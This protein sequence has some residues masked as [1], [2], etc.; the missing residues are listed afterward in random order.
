MSEVL[1]ELLLF[2]Y[3]DLLIIQ[4]QIIFIIASSLTYLLLEEKVAMIQERAGMSY[5]R[6][7]ILVQMNLVIKG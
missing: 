3:L 5:S 6:T 2:L 1:K 7:R 4:K